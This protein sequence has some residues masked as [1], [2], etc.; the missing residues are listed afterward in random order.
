MSFV[1]QALIFNE[2]QFLYGSL[3]ESRKEEKHSISSL[4]ASFSAQSELNFLA[5][6]ALQV[7]GFPP[8]PNRIQRRCND[9]IAEFL[10]P[11]SLPVGTIVSKSPGLCV[12]F[13]LCQRRLRAKVSAKMIFFG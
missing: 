4:I 11:K 2:F 10:H 6:S 8:V 1:V 13:V 12:S 5:L 9:D 7:F 3:Y